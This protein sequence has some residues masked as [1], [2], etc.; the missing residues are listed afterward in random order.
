MAD[1]D[2]DFWTGVWDCTWDGGSGTNTVTKQMDGHVIVEQ[3]EAGGPEPFSGMSVS[4]A[5]PAT[6]GWRQTWVDSTGSYWAFV[7]GRRSDGTVVF[8]TADRVDAE[9]Q[10]KRMTFSDITPDGF[11]WR[12]EASPDRREWTLRW[13]IRY[14]RRA[15]ST[16]AH[17]A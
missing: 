15:S 10:Y 11:T 6:G 4:V 12:W 7:G 17:D 14:R 16:P 1:G 13:A 3:F 8:G 2:L 9:Q 5:D